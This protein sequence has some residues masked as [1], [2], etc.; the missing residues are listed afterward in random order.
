MQDHPVRAMGM[1]KV[2]SGWASGNLQ[3]TVGS[4]TTSVPLD[5]VSSAIVMATRVAAVLRGLGLTVTPYATEAGVLAWSCSGSF[6]Y[7]ASG[8]IQ[9]RLGLASTASG[10][11]VF[12]TGAHYQGWYPEHGMRIMGSAA[13]F[14]EDALTVADGSASTGP[15]LGGD[16]LRLEAHASIAQIWQLEDDFTSGDAWDLWA[17]GRWRGRLRVENVERMRLGKTA[18]HAKLSIDARTHYAVISS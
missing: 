13:L 4:S 10:S 9:S 7:S 18:T 14:T 15:Q 6:A 1:A 2:S 5:D 3:L 16:A 11:H 17:A 8:V 12:G